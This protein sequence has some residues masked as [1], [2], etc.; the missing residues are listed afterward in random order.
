[1]LNV[2]NEDPRKLNPETFAMYYKHGGVGYVVGYTPNLHAIERKRVMV[3]SCGMNDRERLDAKKDA[4]WQDYEC[5]MAHCRKLREQSG[6]PDYL[7]AAS[8]AMVAYENYK[9]FCQR[10]GYPI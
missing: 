1:M 10:E 6:G 5:K 3:R 4:M 8:A 7:Q 9:A 2:D